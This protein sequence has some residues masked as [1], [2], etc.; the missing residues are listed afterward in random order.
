MATLCALLVAGRGQPIS[1][2]RYTSFMLPV[3]IAVAI[4]MWQLMTISM[5]GA[6]RTRRIFAFV[7]PAVLL[8]GIAKTDK[9]YRASLGQVVANGGK[10]ATGSF[11]IYDA[12]VHQRDWISPDP[13][14]G[15]RP[16]ALAIWKQLLP[17]RG[18]GPSV[19]TP[20]ACFLIAGRKRTSLSECLPAR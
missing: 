18:S 15:V 11:S 19:S 7:L 10:F 1:F 12:Y 17:A 5:T 14:G 8:I 6:P 3:M 16:W 4:A 13:D 9:T 2:A 20:I